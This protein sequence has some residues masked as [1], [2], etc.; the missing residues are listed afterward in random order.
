VLGQHGAVGPLD[1]GAGLGSH[2]VKVMGMTHHRSKK[3]SSLDPSPMD[4]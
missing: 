3:T 2:F 1:V 4:A